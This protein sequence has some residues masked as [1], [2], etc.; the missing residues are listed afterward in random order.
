MKI[1]SL[2]TLLISILLIALLTSNSPMSFGEQS[3]NTLDPNTFLDEKIVKL[4]YPWEI[5][6]GAEYS[7]KF[8][9]Y[10][11]QAKIL[12]VNVGFTS[13][14]PNVNKELS[15]IKKG[16]LVYS[17]DGGIWAFSND[18]EIQ[19][20]F[21]ILNISVGCKLQNSNYN[22]SPNYSFFRLITGFDSY[23]FKSGGGISF[24]EWTDARGIKSVN[25]RLDGQNQFSYLIPKDCTKLVLRVESRLH[26]G[27]SGAMLYKYNGVIYNPP[28]SNVRPAVTENRWPEYT[29]FTFSTPKIQVN[30]SSTKTSKSLTSAK[31]TS[32]STISASTSGQTKVKEGGSCTQ[33]GKISNIS[34]E[35]FVCGKVGSK[36]IWIAIASGVKPSKAPSA[37][38]ATQ[39]CSTDPKWLRATV[40]QDTISEPGFALSALIFENLSNC[41]LSISATASFICPD[42]GTLKLSNSILSTGNFPLAPREKLIISRPNQVSRFFPQATQQCY[43]LTGYRTN[44]VNI[45]TYSNNNQIRSVILSSTP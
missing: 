36:L 23:E 35:N 4:T 33:A 34:G 16:E 2:R 21:A 8:D 45:N 40:G 32:K 15:R 1:K 9:S 12:N 6:D 26:V 38:T 31:P 42:G 5:N 44:L 7:V 27:Y 29:I 13:K 28:S 37:S 39:T 22:F 11:Q 25:Q 24:K 14:V 17:T 30:A 20:M 18:S 3:E 43:S 41:N 19:T 10:P